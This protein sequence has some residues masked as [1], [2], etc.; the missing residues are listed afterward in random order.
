M[1]GA[2]G[3]SSVDQSNELTRSSVDHPSQPR[4]AL[5]MHLGKACDDIVWDFYLF[6]SF[7]NGMFREVEISNTLL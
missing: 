3:R 2:M 4:R 7:S 5:K 6:L 1:E